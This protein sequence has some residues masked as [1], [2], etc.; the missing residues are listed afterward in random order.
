MICPTCK[1]TLETCGHLHRAGTLPE[2]AAQHKALI[3]GGF[4]PDERINPDLLPARGESPIQTVRKHLE[5]VTA[6][7]V[8]S[9][10]PS[11]F[12]PA[13]GKLI[14]CP[15][16]RIAWTPDPGPCSR[17]RRLA[18]VGRIVEVL[19]RDFRFRWNRQDFLAGL[20]AV[21]FLLWDHAATAR[22]HRREL[23][24]AERDAQVDSRDAYA[25][26]VQDERER[27]DR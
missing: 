13:V 10:M 24:D 15:L 7:G 22:N 21:A 18:N 23:R 6:H 20:D 8:P 25:A 16:C 19:S 14:P 1:G 2:I 12:Q 5:A 26:G 17:C 3:A 9:D 11:P 27:T 4:L